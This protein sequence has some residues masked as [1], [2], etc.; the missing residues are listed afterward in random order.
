MRLLFVC[1]LLLLALATAES[2]EETQPEFEPTH[3]CMIKPNQK[4][5]LSETYYLEWCSLRFPSWFVMVNANQKF[6]AF[7]YTRLMTPQSQEPIEGVK[8][9]YLRTPRKVW[10]CM[11]REDLPDHKL[12]WNIIPEDFMGPCTA[13]DLDTIEYNHPPPPRPPQPSPPPSPSTS[14]DTAECEEGKTK[15]SCGVCGGDDACVG[16]DGKAHS[17]MKTDSCGVCGG[18]DDC[19]TSQSI[20]AK[21]TFCVLVVCHGIRLNYALSQT[22]PKLTAFFWLMF[23]VITVSLVHWAVKEYEI[24][25]ISTWQVLLSCV[26]NLDLTRFFSS[27]LDGLFDFEMKTV[28]GKRSKDDASF[29]VDVERFWV[30]VILLRIVVLVFLFVSCTKL[31]FTCTMQSMPE[32]FTFVINAGLACFA[33]YVLLW[34]LK[35]P[36]ERTFLQ[37]LIRFQAVQNKVEREKCKPVALLIS[38]AGALLA[39]LTFSINEGNFFY[40]FLVYVTLWFKFYTGC[41]LG[42]ADPSRFHDNPFWSEILH[43]MQFLSAAFPS[44]S[45]AYICHVYMHLVLLVP[46]CVHFHYPVV[47]SCWKIKNMDIPWT[48]VNDAGRVPPGFQKFNLVAH[49]DWK[50]NGDTYFY[51]DEETSSGYKSNV[52]GGFAVCLVLILQNNFFDGESST[53]YSTSFN[54]CHEIYEQLKHEYDIKNHAATANYTN[55]ASRKKYALVDVYTGKRPC[56]NVMLYTFVSLAFYALLLYCEF[57]YGKHADTC[58]ALLHK[59]YTPEL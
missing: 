19:F 42:L 38:S 41:V 37:I 58:D 14:K 56:T 31:Y 45:E 15:D 36:D 18:N 12:T 21:F 2:S 43:L 20:I 54:N 46:E 16:C 29:V 22:Q 52:N 25:T 44:Y 11:S 9:L 33:V 59:W 5:D 47:C 30:L 32:R 51:W 40:C 50:V 48:L 39:S 3:F 28:D 27:K 7:N 35:I 34:T 26:I 1:T 55:H 17:N 23:N 24:A 8:E 53:V 4:L 6:L 10:L 13:D 57:W 49:V